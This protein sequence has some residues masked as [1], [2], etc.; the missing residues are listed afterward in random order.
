MY[1]LLSQFISH[2]VKKGKLCL[3]DGSDDGPGQEHMMISL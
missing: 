3:H 1:S 2:H